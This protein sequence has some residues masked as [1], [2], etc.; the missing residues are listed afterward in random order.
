MDDLTAA[1]HELTTCLADLRCA[2]LAAT[3]AR[4]K[5]TG[6]RHARAEQLTDMLTEAI[7]YCSRLHTCVTGDVRLELMTGGRP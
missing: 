7:S 4:D 2:R 6:A 1:L 3:R 5:L